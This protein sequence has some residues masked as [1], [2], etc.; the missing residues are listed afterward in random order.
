M[1]HYYNER[2][3]LNPTVW[4]DSQIHS[5]LVCLFILLQIPLQ[6]RFHLKLNTI[7]QVCLN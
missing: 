2:E 6:N 5:L 3:K 7:L 4:L 1:I